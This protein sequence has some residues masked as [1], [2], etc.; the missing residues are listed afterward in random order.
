[1]FGFILFILLLVILWPLL[2][3]GWQL[4]SNVRKVK[5]FMADP[6]EYYRR[7]AASSGQQQAY[8]RPHQR[9]KSKKIS[10]DVGEYV[11]FEEVETTTARR[12]TDGTESV[13][14]KSESQVTDI[15]WED[16]K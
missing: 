4:W 3:M 13:N 12:E 16:I 11:A 5:Q 8:T 9:Q 14:Y 15:E 1:M 7:Q 6:A 2:K 10:H